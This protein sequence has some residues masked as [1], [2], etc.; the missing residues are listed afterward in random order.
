MDESTENE[1]IGTTI[2]YTGII[3]Y[4]VLI[5]LYFFTFIY[6]FNTSSQFLFYICVFILNFFLVAFILNDIYSNK[7]IMSSLTKKN[8][9][10]MA[11]LALYAIILGGVGQFT[12]LIVS[13]IVFGYAT[14]QVKEAKKYFVINDFKDILFQFKTTIVT[15]TFFIGL[16]AFLIVYMYSPEEYKEYLKTIVFTGLTCGILGL[17]GY[18]L[19]LSVDFLKVK[20]KKLKLYNI[21]E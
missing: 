15:S 21:I 14:N 5:I 1:S 8:A 7:S 9:S 18:Q 3:K 19:K 13:L 6:I 11:R 12:S 4:S 16:T 17:V 2:G 20:Q 10:L